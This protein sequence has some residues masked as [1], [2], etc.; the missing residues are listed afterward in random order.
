M[1]G[2]KGRNAVLAG[3]DFDTRFLH[4]MGFKWRYSHKHAVQ[5]TSHAPNIHLESIPA[6]LPLLENFRSDVVGCSTFLGASVLIR[7]QTNA[8][9][10]VSQFEIHVRGEEAILRFHVGVEN[11]IGMKVG[12]CLG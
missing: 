3:M 1:V 7:S 10:K 12:N 11:A 2:N 4:G 5:D 8:Q 6:F 9:A